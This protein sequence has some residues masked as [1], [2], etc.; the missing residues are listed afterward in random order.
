MEESQTVV[1]IGGGLG[2]LSAA[3]SLRQRG[4]DVTLYEKNTHFGG[5]LNRHEQDGF[6]FDLGPSLLTMPHVFER[7]FTGS[8]KAMDDYV[9]IEEIPLQWRA[10][11]PDDSHIDLYGN[12][13]KMAEENPQF[14]KE[15]MSDYRNFLEYAKKIDRT[16]VPGYF[17]KGL[18]DLKDVLR[19]HGPIEA[20]KG[21]DYPSTMQHGIN[22]R[23]KNPHMR[24]M[25]GYF[26]KYVGSSSYRAPAV[27]NM[28]AH[29]QHEQGVWYV[30]GGLHRLAEGITQLA[31]DI[32]IK[33]YTGVS[34]ETALTDGQNNIETLLLNDGSR[35]EADYYVSNMEVLPFYRHVL[36]RMP[37]KFEKLEKQFEPASSGLV[38]HL[39]V[40]RKYPQL[41]HHNFFFSNDS[42]RN[43]EEVFEKKIIPGDPTI[44]VVNTNKTDPSQAPEGYENLKILPHIPPL[45]QEQYTKED[46]M[47][48]R[49]TVLEKLESM[50][51]E[52]LRN[53]IVTEYMLTPHD[54]EKMYNSD[55][56]A[57]YGTVS[58][59]KKNKGFKHPKKDREIGNL[60]FVGGTV[61]P[62]GGMPMVTL[63]GQQVGRMISESADRE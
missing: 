24:D 34:V 50:G 46:Y 17:E 14:G 12:L 3:I 7:L 27:L 15:D 4:F 35:I 2:G 60:Y 18:D 31:R 57:I 21:F 8:G 45:Q 9:Q 22:K 36:D 62:G 23:V 5:K 38:L 56:G 43:Y 29:M 52:N 41:R 47:N 48:F 1:V 58:D 32:G 42:K 55:H 53:H 44:Y 40:N 61:N 59:K 63:S 28:M 11:F 54:I 13:Q 10:F 49:S 37:K 39:G 6:G 33:L 26:I 30:K 20:F 51:L 19:F 16:T 25:L